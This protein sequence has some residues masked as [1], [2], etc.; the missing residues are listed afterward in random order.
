MITN[1]FSMNFAILASIDHILKNHYQQ[2]YYKFKNHYF[3]T[4]LRL[5]GWISKVFEM[6]WEFQ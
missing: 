6:M 3:P 2:E 4:D 5:E 1:L